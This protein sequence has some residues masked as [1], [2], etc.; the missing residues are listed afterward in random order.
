MK[1]ERVDV[2]ALQECPFY[3]YDMA[4]LGWR[5]YYGGDLCLVSRYPF[6]VLDDADPEHA[7][8]SGGQKPSVRD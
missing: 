3:N 5:F 2:A 4:R 6:A 8:R 7:W 1:A